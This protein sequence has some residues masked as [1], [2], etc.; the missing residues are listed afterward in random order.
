MPFLILIVLEMLE[1]HESPGWGRAVAMKQAFEE[2]PVA[3]AYTLPGKMVAIALVAIGVLM[4]GLTI[5]DREEAGILITF[6]VVV[7]GIAAVLYHFLRR[8]DRENES[9]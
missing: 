9:T 7:F 1:K 5:I 3:K 6:A 2:Q 4:T 8:A